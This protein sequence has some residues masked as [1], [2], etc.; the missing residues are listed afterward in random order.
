MAYVF[1]PESYLNRNS[2]LQNQQDVKQIQMMKYL[3]DKQ[4][5]AKNLASASQVEQAKAGSYA[6]DGAAA[7][8]FLNYFSD[9]PQ[10][11]QSSGQLWQGNLAQ[12][13]GKEKMSQSEYLAA[14]GELNNPKNS[15]PSETSSGASVVPMSPQPKMAEMTLETLIPAL[16][17]QNPRLA[18][19]QGHPELLNTIQLFKDRLEEGSKMRLAQYEASLKP[20]ETPTGKLQQDINRGL[21]TPGSEGPKLSIA[22]LPDAQSRREALDSQKSILSAPSV[23]KDLKQAAEFND[24]SFDSDLIGADTKMEAARRTGTYKEELQNTTAYE[25]VVKRQILP[26]MK[27]L[28]GARITNVDL[29]LMKDIELGMTKTKAER[30]ILLQAA[31]DAINQRSQTARD[32]LDSLGVKIS[33]PKDVPE[34]VIKP[35]P[36]QQNQQQSAASAQPPMP[37]AK[38]APDGNWYLPDPNRPGKYLQVK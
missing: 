24:K 14:V 6:V 26:Q 17:R 29:G 33:E 10:Q 11:A 3:Q 1:Y 38:Q 13:A 34:T 37:N 36:G 25:T 2:D 5:A 4:D 23:I 22:Q 28:F 9:S 21:V 30:A 8:N 15:K 12:P 7:N 19:P 35:I 16:Q 18:T 32:F 27:Q 20:A 31:E